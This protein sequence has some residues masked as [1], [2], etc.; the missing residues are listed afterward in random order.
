METSDLE[1]EPTE[2]VTR[3]RNIGYA[4]VFTTQSEPILP[5][6]LYDALYERGFL[7]GF[8]DADATFAPMADAGLADAVFTV[9]GEPYRILS[10]TS[11]KGNGCKVWVESCTIADLPDEYRARR[12]VTK[13]KLVYRVEAGGPSNSDRNLCENIAEALMLET[14]GLVEIGGLGT[15]GNR[16]QLYHSSWLGSI[17]TH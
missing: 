12:A 3:P 13:P 4:S 10:M 15:K 8:T 14:S 17:K 2:V 6:T 11:S 1:Q 7:P 5:V 16:P 9:G